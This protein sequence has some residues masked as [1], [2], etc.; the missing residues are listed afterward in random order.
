[1][2]TRARID[3][4]GALHHV[5][6]KGIEHKKI[7]RSDFVRNNLLNRFYHL[8]RQTRTDF[9]AWALMPTKQELWRMA[10]RFGDPISQRPSWT[11]GWIT[12][13]WSTSRATATGCASTRLERPVYPKLTKI[14]C[15]S[16]Q[17]G[18]GGDI[19]GIPPTRPPSVL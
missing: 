6:A 1:M 3:A 10:G 8:I 2:P 16:R 5:I 13:R 14:S 15:P 4:P 19:L 17:P 11:G 9:F 7:F 12:A 18:S